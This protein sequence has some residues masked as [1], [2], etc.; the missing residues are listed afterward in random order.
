[1]E[2]RRRDAGDDDAEFVLDDPLHEES[3]H[4]PAKRR[5]Y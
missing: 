5:D 1:M 4:D 3:E 2:E